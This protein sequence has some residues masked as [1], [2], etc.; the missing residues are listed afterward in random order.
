MLK[1]LHISNYAI[2]EEV[3]ISLD[4]GLSIITGETG[5]GKSI[6]LGAL[7][8]VMGKRADTSVLFTNQKKCIVEAI[9]DLSSYDLKD[10]FGSKE[11]DYDQECIVRREISPSGKSRAFINDTP[12]TLSILKELSVKLVDLHQQFDQL[13]INE[14]ASQINALDAVSDNLKLVSDFKKKYHQYRKLVSTIDD[15][16]SKIKQNA[17]EEDY[18]KFQLQEFE[19][20]ELKE[21]E[22]EE[23]EREQN[24]LNNSE[25]IK[26]IG[27]LLETSLQNDD[28]SVTEVLDQLIRELRSIVDFDPIAQDIRDKLLNVREEIS[29]IAH[30]SSRMS[31]EIEYNPNRVYEIEERLNLI[32]RLLNKYQVQSSA[33]LMEIEKDL[34][35]KYE[36]FN[37]LDQNLEE[38]EKEATEKEKEL[39]KLANVISNNRSKGGK[40]LQERI[41][42]ILHDLSMKNAQL[43]VEIINNQEI[44]ETGTDKVNFIFSANKGSSFLP[45]SKVASGGELSRINLALKSTIAGALTLPTLIFDEIDSGVSGQVALMMGK[46][47]NQL[48]KDHQTIC[49]THSP[50]IAAQADVH[51]QIYKTDKENRTFTH[52]SKLDDKERRIEIAKMLSGDPPSEEALNN[53]KQLLQLT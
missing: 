15:I 22:V 17:Q 12:V 23:L 29:D 30:L 42:S 9:Y 27:G 10:F 8:L 46:I 20:M 47:L 25:E 48:S 16:K 11:L 43:K 18:L 2:I 21:N 38:L 40:I 32:N 13:E 4:S 52:V 6:L 36:S 7:G 14:E 3:K 35:D 50:Q 31:E 53:A 45:L 26:R 44:R 28:T 49:I 37:K 51:Y 24:L 34:V 5:A 41:N 1:T 39:L 19:E 33:E